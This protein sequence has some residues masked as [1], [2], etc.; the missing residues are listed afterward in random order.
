M[1]RID[2]IV[3]VDLKYIT[4]EMGWIHWVGLLNL[5]ISRKLAYLCISAKIYCSAYQ[6]CKRE[7]ICSVRIVKY[8]LTAAKMAATY[9]ARLES[10]KCI[11][12]EFLLVIKH[13]KRLCPLLSSLL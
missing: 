1:F 3:F 10:A 11:Y 7:Y 12:L 4:L 2:I 13:W 6:N 9:I 5:R 8:L